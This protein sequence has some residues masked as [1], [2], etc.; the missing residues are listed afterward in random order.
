MLP[1]RHTPQMKC[2]VPDLQTGSSL[3]ATSLG[4]SLVPYLICCFDAGAVMR[5][6]GVGFGVATRFR[7]SVKRGV[8]ASAG[9]AIFVVCFLVGGPLLVP[10]EALA[11]PVPPPIFAG[12]GQ[13]WYLGAGA[14][15]DHMNDFTE[16]VAGTGIKISDRQ[17]GVFVAGSFGYKW[18]SNLRLEFEVGYTSH[19]VVAPFNG[20]TANTTFMVNGMYDIPIANGFGASVGG[21][22]GA[23]NF[24]FCTGFGATPC[25]GGTVTGFAGQVIGE[26]N[27]A[28]TPSATVFF[29]G[30]GRFFALNEPIRD[31]NEQAFM[32]GFRVF[33]WPDQR[34]VLA[35]KSWH[36]AR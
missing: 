2:A 3:T 18:A 32:V 29:Q 31:V 10:S 12:A 17:E 20:N 15:F 35:P 30:R 36:P 34:A 11:Q 16:L 28:M 8:F 25:T 6:N 22:I 9:F 26:L 19:E 24:N 27:F 5:G 23:A 21:G 4:S 33:P 1:F 14:G 7:E 13:G